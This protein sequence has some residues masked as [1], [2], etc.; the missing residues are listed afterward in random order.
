MVWSTI[1]FE[2]MRGCASM[3][4][5]GSEDRREHAREDGVGGTEQMLIDA[6]FG[7]EDQVVIRPV[8]GA[9]SERHLDVRQEVKQRDAG[10]I[11][12]G[13]FNLSKNEIEVRANKLDH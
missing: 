5:R 2:M 13:Y 12:F 4:V 8:D 1:R 7:V 3:T 11:T 10:C 6:R 9:Q